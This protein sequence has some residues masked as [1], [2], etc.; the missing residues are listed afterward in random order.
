MNF[1]KSWKY[2]ILA[3]GLAFTLI[4]QFS[5][6]V[7]LIRKIELSIT[8]F[9]REMLIMSLVIFTLIYLFAE[10][11]NKF[12]ILYR[13]YQNKSKS[14]TIKVNLHVV[15][16]IFTSTLLLTL[17]IYQVRMLIIGNIYQ[18]QRAHGYYLIEAQDKI[19]H[20]DFEG[21]MAEANTCVE[22]LSNHKCRKVAKA[23]E[24][25]IFLSDL[26]ANIADQKTHNL[27][28]RVEM[29][30]DLKMLSGNSVQ[31]DSFKERLDRE[32]SRASKVLFSAIQKIK[33]KNYEEGIKLLDDT[34]T[35]WGDFGHNQLI[36]REVQSV[37]YNGASNTTFPFLNKLDSM[38]PKEFTELI[39]SSSTSA[40]TK[41]KFF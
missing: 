26:V 40:Y 2:Y 31:L 32:Y 5:E 27:T 16:L 34:N 35:I 39:I 38:T 10:L 21:A 17:I 15:F 14:Q 19:K 8:L 6:L 25:R 3:L 36:K 20:L 18:Y 9:G 28:G 33:K 7:T 12:P 37:Y 23:L 24:K 13:A 11:K 1:I 22:L 30:K 29:L 4:F 41:L